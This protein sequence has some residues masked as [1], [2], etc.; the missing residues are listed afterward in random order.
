MSVRQRTC[1]HRKLEV[2][3]EKDRCSWIEC[4]LCGKKGPNK[5]SY[6]LAILAWALHLTNQHP[7]GR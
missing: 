6:T 4:S 7:R 5:H 3:T 2:R 1:T